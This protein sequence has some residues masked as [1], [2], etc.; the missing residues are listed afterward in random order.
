MTQSMHAAWEMYLI[1][2]ERATV[3]GYCHWSKLERSCLPVTWY[4]R[5]PVKSVPNDTY[6]GGCATCTWS[7][8]REIPGTPEIKRDPQE[9]LSTPKSKK[10]RRSKGHAELWDLVDTPKAPKRRQATRLSMRQTSESDHGSS[11][12][13][14]DVTFVETYRRDPKEYEY[15]SVSTTGKVR[16]YG[17]A[18]FYEDSEEDYLSNGDVSDHSLE[19]ERNEE[20]EEEDEETQSN[21]NSCLKVARL[22]FNVLHPTDA[23]SS[24]TLFHRAM[25]K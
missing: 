7:K 22:V 16:E 3:H 1:L 21:P 9:V 25:R 17:K 19:Y 12:T 24:L 15:Y 2:M 18:E 10:R 14:E 5:T 13:V 23:F 8:D 6:D 20:D 11:S 4:D